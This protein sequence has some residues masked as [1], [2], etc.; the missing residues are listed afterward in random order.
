MKHRKIYSVVVEYMVTLLSLPN[1]VF[2][3]AYKQKDLYINSER[4]QITGLSLS[5][6]SSTN[7]HL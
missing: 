3:T 4:M 1:D 5:N 7:K 2:T 6:F